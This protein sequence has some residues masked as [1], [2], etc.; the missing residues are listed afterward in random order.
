[1]ATLNVYTEYI[2]GLRTYVNVL[3]RSLYVHACV[4]SYG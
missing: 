1:M 3:Y 4:L 2:L